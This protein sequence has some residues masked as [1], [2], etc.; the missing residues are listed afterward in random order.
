MKTTILTDIEG[1]TSSISFV[2]DVLFPYARDAL[3]DFVREH[4]HD[5]RV[6][7]WLD[8]VAV[9]NGGL[10]QDAMIAET[11]QGWID[12]DRKHTALKALQG[13]IWEAGYREGD[14]TAPLY[15]DVAPALRAWH[16][17]GHGL[18]VYSSGSVP[19]QK[20]LFSHTD[21]GDLVPLFRD[22]FDTEIGHKRDAD[23]YRLIADRLDRSPGD[24]LFLSDVVAE[25]DAAREAGMRT[26]LL[27][28]IEDY[29]QPRITDDATHGHARAEAF[30]Q[31]TP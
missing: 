20:L 24:I 21:A 16:A 30:S 7:H 3:P 26:V 6:R 23:S 31:V 2:R 13:L 4:G 12:Q 27:D 22:F 17:A 9:E 1:T 28:R 8:V 25:L 14:F 18:A 29:P 19:A 10:C 5:P 11:L 15:P